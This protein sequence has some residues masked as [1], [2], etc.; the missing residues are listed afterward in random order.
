M[1][2]LDIWSVNINGGWLDSGNLI[3]DGPMNH[4]GDSD[5]I[6]KIMVE[7]N[8]TLQNQLMRRGLH[9]LINTLSGHLLSDVRLFNDNF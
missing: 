1:R 6:Y 7:Y 3:A 5:T 8:T 9:Q 4:G 2:G